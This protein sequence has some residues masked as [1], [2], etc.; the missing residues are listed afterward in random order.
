MFHLDTL[1]LIRKTI[2]R[3]L[4]IFL[5]VFIGVCFMVG[6]LTTTPIMHKSVDIYYDEYNFMDVQLYSSYGFD[7]EDIKAIKDTKNID[8]VF[9]T[10]YVDVFSSYEDTTY[11]TRVQEL[12]SD[13][14]K[15]E[16]TSGRMPRELNEALII[17]DADFDTLVPEGDTITVFLEDGDI[18]DSLKSTEFK[19]V[20][21]ARSP[22]YMANQLE[23]SNLNNLDI[24][25]VIYVKNENFVADY[26]TSVYVTFKDAKGYTAF[27]KK[28]KN[29]IADNLKEL[30]DTA[31]LQQDHR[32]NQI[33]KEIEDKIKEG[34]E[35]F[36]K[37]ISSAQKKINKG[38]KEL[39][40]A[41]IQ[42]LVGEATIKE[43]EKQLEDG[44]KELET[45][46]EILEKNKKQI[47]DGIKQVE[48]E[49]GK[50]FDEAIKSIDQLYSVYTAIEDI[51]DK[52]N[53]SITV[54]EKI[55]ENIEDILKIEKENDKLQAEKIRLE[56]F[57]GSQEEIDDIEVKIRANNIKIDAIKAEN[58]LL[59]FVLTLCENSPLNTVLKLLDKLAGGSVKESY[60]SLH[61][62][63]DGKKQVED[64]LIQIEKGYKELEA[65]KE[66]LKKAKEDLAQGRKDYEAGLRQ[67][68]KAQAELDA[69]SEKARIELDKA[70]QQLE[71]LPSSGWILLDRDSHYSTVLYDNNSAQMN[72]IGTIFPLIFFAVAALVCMTTMKRLVDEQRSQIGVF[73]AL[74]FTKNQII[75]KYVMYAFIASLPASLIGMVLGVPT[76]PVVIYVCWGL[77][78]NLPPMKLFLPVHAGA[79]GVASFTILMM[80]VTYFVAKDTLGEMP[81]QLMRP[82]APKKA[83]K[84][85]LEYIPFIWNRLSFTSKVTARNLIRYKSRFFMTVLGVVGCTSLLVLGFGV[86]DS[87]SQTIDV[88][89]GEVF[90]YDY[91]I[92]LE[93]FLDFD[94]I[95]AMVDEDRNIDSAVPFIS[96][97]SKVY[98]DDEK[99]ITVQVVDEDDYKDI[100]SLR[101]RVKKKEL[102]LDDGAV[103]SEKFAKSNN[104]KVGDYVTIESSN[105]IKKEVKIGGICEMYFQHYLFI[106]T[107][108]YEKVFNETVRYDLIAICTENGEEFIDDYE[109]HEKIKNITDFSTMKNRFQSMIEAL[110]IIVIVILLA[111][112]SLAFV[113]LINLTEVNI[114]ERIRE[115][116]TLK[117]LGFFDGE[118]NSYIF[119]EILLLALIG[120]VVGLPIGK[121]ML[122]FVMNIIDMEM[123]MFGNEI[124]L[125]SYFYSFAITMGFAIVVLISMTG[126][127]KKVEMVESLKSVE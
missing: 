57:G 88:Q 1:R 72:K 34:E 56:I 39:E 62:L 65:A 30:E 15:F 76:F 101:T 52:T 105:G 86:K 53:G 114:S 3:F 43:S 11:V 67:L 116:A 36:N 73:S 100:L 19:I 90:N 40:D 71:E 4:T 20:G 126:T 22:Q 54:K 14:N 110:D 8:D 85:F 33:I 63:A 24:Q 2:K 58:K 113:V 98:F 83:K 104:L 117:V 61:A 23:T 9:A 45:N 79:I 103:V 102:T 120:A 18:K 119:K 68:N 55:N 121:V 27:S 46:K 60:T 94:E 77:M 59:Y 12:D 109:D 66:K 127:L 51:V 84:V 125:L 64:G 50:S 16:L 92:T 87:I 48:K 29:F 35:E 106:S 115:I 49:T 107:Q 82:K 124:K 97:S 99:T 7:D 91:T 95:Y 26:Y 6:L 17:G 96:Y 75:G 123:M 5:M 13:V 37:Q 112:G 41:Y 108:E 69:E 74:G 38:R 118:V 122:G 111:S 28:Y 42:L 81:S 31:S 80:V 10:K 21:T 78:Y 70:R 89:I 44:Y 47:D 93:D 25:N 32:K